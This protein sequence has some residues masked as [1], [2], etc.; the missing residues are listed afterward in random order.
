VDSNLQLMKEGGEKYGYKLTNV[1]LN[2]HF[3]GFDTGTQIVATFQCEQTAQQLQQPT[4]R[5]QQSTADEMTFQR[6]INKTKILGLPIFCK[7]LERLRGARF[8]WKHCPICYC[9]EI[10]YARKGIEPSESDIEDVLEWVKKSRKWDETW[11]PDFERL[12]PS[13]HFYFELR[14]SSGD[15]KVD[16]KERKTLFKCSECGQYFKWSEMRG[17]MGPYCAYGGRYCHSCFAR[18]KGGTILIPEG[19]VAFEKRI[20]NLRQQGLIP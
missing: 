15:A 17:W 20:K 10:I 11:V 6:E 7:R 14:P 5:P 8:Y 13:D 1:A 9:P 4:H 2:P 18:T 12:H 3:C 16:I 19:E